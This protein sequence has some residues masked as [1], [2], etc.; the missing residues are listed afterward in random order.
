MVSRPG[1]IWEAAVQIQL[2][3]DHRDLLLLFAAVAHP[4]ECCGL[5]FGRDTLIEAVHPV[6]NIAAEPLIRFEIDPATLIAAHRRARMG[7][8]AILGY[9]H[10][11]PSGAP[12]MSARDRAGIGRAGEIWL[13]VA[14]MSLEGYISVGNQ[15][16]FTF[17]PVEIVLVN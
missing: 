4:Q 5:L 6:D 12:G 9:Y 7:G 17:E 1:Y 16:G 2:R 8:P 11:H 14:G 15:S 13:L 3:H 10:S